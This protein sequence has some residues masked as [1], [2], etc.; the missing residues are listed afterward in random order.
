MSIDDDTRL[1]HPFSDMAVVRGAELVLTKGEDVWLWD[2]KGRRYLDVSA[3]LWYANVGHGRHEIADAVSA[4]M[5]E[6]EAY[7]IFGNVANEPAL[8]LADRLSEL[9]PMDDARVFLT[10]GGGE[11]IDAAAKIARRFWSVTGQPSR[12]HLISRIGGY[13]GTNGFGTSLGG[14]EA[15][16]TGFGALIPHTSYV[17]HDSVEALEQEIQRLG[18]DNVAAFFMEPIIG[19]GGVF[20]PPEGYIEGV[21]EVCEANG[22]LLM[23]DSVI[24]GFGRLG[25]WFGIERWDVVPDLITFAKGVSSG[26]LPVG[27]VVAS[28]RVAEPFW[29]EPGTV[30]R[31]GATYAGHP[32]C[33]AAALANIDILEREDLVGRAATLEDKLA[34]T[35]RPLE[36]HPLVTEVRAGIGLM[37][38]VGLQAPSLAPLLYSQ[39]VEQGVL[40]RALGEAIAV[41]PPLTIQEQEIELIGSEF[42]TALDAVHEVAAAG[43]A[44]GA[45]P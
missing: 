11:A 1:W 17:P 24:C 19:A 8:K 32:A 21:A 42:R 18:A 5:K 30:L 39:L 13:H 35:L 41:S 25:T 27:G 29:T 33:A 6:L 20:L 4:Q 14:I 40:T 10:T 16:R 44:A 15:N 28:W 36:D 3:S 7:S 38:A 12:Q 22:V 31:Q 37:A 45:R 26:Y 9:A 2:D 43:T 23:V 34:D